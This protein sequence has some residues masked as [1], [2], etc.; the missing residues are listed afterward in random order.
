MLP[1]RWTGLELL[2]ELMEIL[3]TATPR[4]GFIDILCRHIQ[5][6]LTTMASACIGSDYFGLLWHNLVRKL[7]AQTHI[8]GL[9]GGDL[10]LQIKKKEQKKKKK[11]QKTKQNETKTTKQNKTKQKTK[12][13]PA[14]FG[15]GVRLT[16]PIFT[17]SILRQHS[18][19]IM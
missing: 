5:L 8:L 18:W 7:H 3:R 19:N 1:M 15:W 17:K 6:A 10:G 16:E 9:D 14:C 11:Q 12:T 4:Q 13:A 2:D